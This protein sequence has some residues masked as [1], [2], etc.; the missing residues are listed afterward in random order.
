MAEYFNKAHYGDQGFEWDPANCVWS[1]GIQET[2][3]G[4]LPTLIGM[5][6][7]V[8]AGTA[9]PYDVEWV[10]KMIEDARAIPTRDI[11]SLTAGWQGEHE[12]QWTDNGWQ[13]GSKDWWSRLDPLSP[14]VGPIALQIKDK[15]DRG[16]ATD[17]EKA[18]FEGVM[19]MGADWDYRASTPQA[20]DAFNPLG[21]QLFGALGTI[22]LGA[23]GGLAAA[24]LFAGGAG[25][26]TTLGSAGTLAGIAGT[27][28]STLG[29]ATDQ[30]WLKRAGQVLGAVGGLAGGASGLA[31][32]WGTGIHSL[33]DAARLASSAGKV[34]GALGSATGVPGLQQA[35]SYLG[36]A[37]NLGQAGSDL[38]AG[39]LGA[40]VPRLLSVLG[41]GRGIA[42]R[43]AGGQEGAPQGAPPR[44]QGQRPDLVRGPAP[45]SQP[46]PAPLPAPMM[47]PGRS[48]P[49]P[50]SIG[51]LLAAAQFAQHGGQLPDWRSILMRGR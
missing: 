51:R 29:A 32:L 19:S 45:T 48:G 26:A 7:Q 41:Q 22:A 15:L 24:P 38:S 33:S 27:G 35:G 42:Q 46:L 21:D 17:Q 50:D 6:D 14:D 43:L 3:A 28:A 13:E 30:P 37:G 31:N 5:L 8:R 20:S 25:L 11:A 9:K 16:T 18:L 49:Q 44:L 39:N 36:L 2:S 47:P 23:T 1:G 4:Y 10:G 34:T 12:G 40:G